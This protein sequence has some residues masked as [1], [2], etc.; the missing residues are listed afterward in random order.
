FLALLRDSARLHG[1][2]LLRSG[3]AAGRA[4]DVRVDPA[5]VLPALAGHLSGA[6]GQ[7]SP[8]LQEVLLDPRPRRGCAGL[9][10]RRASG[11]ALCDDLPGRCGLL[12]RALPDRSSADLAL[13]KAVAA[14]E[15]DHRSG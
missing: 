12:F 11:R 9:L 7:L 8:D 14:A 10:R 5:A 15:L 6:F 13:R 1:G 4:R 2:F 3:E